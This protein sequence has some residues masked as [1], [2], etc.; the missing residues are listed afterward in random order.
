MAQTRAISRACRSAFAH[1][2]VMMDAGLSTTPAEEVPLGGFDDEPR[3]APRNITPKAEPKRREPEQVID[4]PPAERPVDRSAQAVPPPSGDFPPDWEDW[5]K[6][7]VAKINRA[8][9]P[10]QVATIQQVN[11]EAL[12]ACAKV[13][14]DTVERMT[15]LVDTKLAKLSE[16]E[17]E[18][19]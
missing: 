6:I 10:E 19:A 17:K 1:V 12:A 13:L 9:S 8:G 4:P 5:R 3:E 14:D 11:A 18:A 16:R 7:I 2:V 15:A